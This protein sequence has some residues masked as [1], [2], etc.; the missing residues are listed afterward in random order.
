[1]STG[2]TERIVRRR[3]RA[4]P[5]LGLLALLVPGV[6]AMATGPADRVAPRSAKKPTM[7]SSQATYQRVGFTDLP[8]WES[9]DHSVAF[10][11]FLKSCVRVLAGVQGAAHKGRRPPPPTLLAA[12]ADA[13]SL[14][15]GTRVD[16][17][18]ARHFFETHFTPHRV[19]HKDGKGLLTGY[20]EPLIRGARKADARFSAPVYR[21]PKDLV[22][23]VAES[24]RGAKGDQLTHARKTETGVAPYPTRAEIEQG[25][26]A[27]QGLELVYLESPVDV[28]FMQV[29]GSG[30]IALPD[31]S[32]IRV[33]YDGKNGHPYT[34]VGRH[35]VETGQMTSEQV[36]LQ[37]LERWLKADAERGRNAMWQNASYVF[38]RELEGEQA[39]APM[40]VLEIPLTEGRSLAVDTAHHSIGLP[41][42]VSAPELTH[43]TG[44]PFQRLM[45]AQD[46]GSAIKGPERADIYFGSGEEA[47]RIAGVTKHAGNLFVLLPSDWPTLMEASRTGA[48]K[49]IRQASQ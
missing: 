38:F 40:G 49:P 28:F 41:V 19:A 11:T 48:P 25:A 31:G 45:V 46:V 23:L 3:H 44:A 13:A 14:A 1:M 20:Y 42:Y 43:A 9:D 16:A 12:C 33:T 6:D 32:T 17:A 35:L 36:S 39:S 8:G 37:R 24:E 7:S 21:R 15:Q 10:Q 30:R 2:P 4:V 26:L 34:S 18:A 29:Q 5:F 22:N 47:G 27:G